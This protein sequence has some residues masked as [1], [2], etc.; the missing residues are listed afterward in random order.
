MLRVRD[1]PPGRPLP[2]AR[3]QPAGGSVTHAHPLSRAG[4]PGAGAA[5]DDPV[6]GGRMPGESRFSGFSTAGPRRKADRVQLLGDSKEFDEPPVCGQCD[7][8]LVR[9]PRLFVRGER[10]RQGAGDGCDPVA[11]V[12]H[13]TLRNARGVSGPEWAGAAAAAGPHRGET[14]WLTAGPRGRFVTCSD[15]AK[16]VPAALM[17]LARLPARGA[18]AQPPPAGY[19]IEV[20]LASLHVVADTLTGLSLLMLPR[21]SSRAREP[22]G[23]VWLRLQPDSALEWIN[24]AVAAIRTPIPGDQSEGIQWSRTLRPLRDSGAVALGRSRKKASWSAPTGWPSPTPRPAGASSSP[25]PRPTV[26]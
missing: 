9:V 11:G 13:D 19:R 16:N 15:R 2:L 8:G 25:P 12:W 4:R 6:A 5:G 26:C 21:A 20:E 22:E 14:W 17:G 24:S 1:L 18:R 23:P 10:Q 3:N 7:V